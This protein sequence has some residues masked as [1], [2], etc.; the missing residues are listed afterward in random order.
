MNDLKAYCKIKKSETVSQPDCLNGSIIW[1]PTWRWY[2]VIH[3]MTQSNIELEIQN[4][5]ISWQ[6]SEYATEIS[7]FSADLHQHR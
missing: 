3:A 6:K 4:K 1:P 5:S 2:S 7:G